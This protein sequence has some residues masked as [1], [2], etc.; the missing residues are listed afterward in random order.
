MSGDMAILPEV[1][2]SSVLYFFYTT[3]VSGSPTN[4]A[5]LK[6]YSYGQEKRSGQD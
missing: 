6:G 3:S 4:M 1:R 2:H 5:F